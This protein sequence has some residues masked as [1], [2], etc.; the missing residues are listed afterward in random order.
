[1][2]FLNDLN[3]QQHQA[4]IA[5]LGPVL[6]L[7]GAGSGKTRALTY[8]MAYLIAT[9]TFA[10]HEILAVTFTNKAANEMRERVEG[11]LKRG[12]MGGKGERDKMGE[13]GE[14]GLTPFNLSH[15]HRDPTPGI[16]TLG[17]FHS[18]CARLLRKEIN[19]LE[20]FTSA[21][22]IFDADDSLRAVKQV[23]KSLDWQ[24]EIAPNFARAVISSIKNQQIKLPDVEQDDF[25]RLFEAYQNLLKE[26]NALDFDD[27][28]LK[29][30]AL[31]EEHPPVLKKY[32]KR[33]PY[34][35]VDEYQDTNNIQYKLIKLLATENVFAVGDDAQSIYGFRGA[36][37]RNILDFERDF[38][39]AQVYTLDENYRSTQ[40]ILSAANEVIK[41]S[42]EQ[43]KKNLW[44]KNPPGEPIVH[45]TAIDEVAE[46]VFVASEILKHASGSTHHATGSEELEYVPEEEPWLEDTDTP[47]F[48]QM[49]K[50]RKGINGNNASRTDLSR[51]AILDLSKL[52]DMAVL[53][54]TNAQSRALEEAMLQFGIPY[55]LVGAVKFYERKEIKDVL[56]FLR[57]LLNP[58]DLV[59]LSRAINIPPRGLGDKSFELISRGQFELLSA[60][61]KTAWELLAAKLES[62][63]NTPADTNL[64]KIINILIKKFDL[65]DFYVDGTSE[66]DSRFENIKELMT[67]AARFSNKPWLEALS[68]FLEE[69]ALY[70]ATDEVGNKGGVTL[71]TLH[72]AKGLEFDTVFMVGLEEGILP[73]M[74]SLESGQDIG[75]EIRLAYVGF[76]RA[77]KNLYLINAYT[78]RIFGA[79]YTLKPSRVLKAVPEE[80][81]ERME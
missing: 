69:I 8:R 10:P 12:V 34:I 52:K 62:M 80:L 17:T 20:P 67:V 71:M 45:Y 22:T 60:R 36:N 54:R 66:G 65:E 58:K 61:A 55:H 64:V 78:R 16:P 57:L 31:F 19:R 75:E 48:D 29:T 47:F 2:N 32:Q 7:A 41:L 6:V 43:K 3:P 56:S 40:N 1:M 25:I 21:F 28:L 18:I 11:L 53:Y 79:S 42:R 15:P 30:V 23:I 39:D 4:V 27:L 50:R 76:T 24:R 72:Q 63:R 35:L 51:S 70:S 44:T 14:T 5:P 46:A 68:E 81:I 49:L 74:K 26:V 38:P 59:S 13:M 73:H 37:F 33:W 9:K 77:R